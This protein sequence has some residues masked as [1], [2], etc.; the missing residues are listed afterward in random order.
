MTVTIE[1]LYGQSTRRESY[2]KNE[3]TDVLSQVRLMVLNTLES[4]RRVWK[5]GVD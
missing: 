3:M 4:G 5:E 2:F 1:S